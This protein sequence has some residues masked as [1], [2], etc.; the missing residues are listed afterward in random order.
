MSARASDATSLQQPASP[1]LHAAQH[2]HTPVHAARS[3]F[4][5]RAAA[6]H[7]KSPFTTRAYCGVPAASTMVKP[8][9][10]TETRPGGIDDRATCST[11]FSLQ[12]RQEQAA[13]GRQVGAG[14]G[15]WSRLLQTALPTPAT[16]THR[17]RRTAPPALLHPRPP[18]PHLSGVLGSATE[19]PLPSSGMPLSPAARTVRSRSCTRAFSAAA[20]R[21]GCMHAGWVG[22]GVDDCIPRAQQAA[23]VLRWRQ[24][25]RRPRERG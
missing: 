2:R 14:R 23:R 11:L 1:R 6:P 16:G 18:K 9:T 17:P 15:G 25:R 7:L 21:P 5:N 8:D 24:R 3:I 12:G 22:R 4:Q 10:V 19:P 20:G 13:D